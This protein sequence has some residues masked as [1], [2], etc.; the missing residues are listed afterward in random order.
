MLCSGRITWDLV[1]E[2]GKR[3]GDDPTTAI[4]R[5][6]QLYPR[7]LE[8]IEGEHP[9]NLAIVARLRPLRIAMMIERTSRVATR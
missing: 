6:E 5:V 9:L 1:V 8:K 3:Q 4:V 7:P 2:R